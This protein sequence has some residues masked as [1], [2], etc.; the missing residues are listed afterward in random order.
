MLAPIMNGP[1]HGFVYPVALMVPAPELLHG[2]ARIA[3]EVE[4]YRFVAVA[5][6]GSEHVT[7]VS[8]PA[9]ILPPEPA[10]TTTTMRYSYRSGVIF[11]RQATEWEGQRFEAEFRPCWGQNLNLMQLDRPES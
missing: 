2:R 11:F 5:S 6:G 4:G 9:R 1:Y 3:W 8:T 7:V 10:R